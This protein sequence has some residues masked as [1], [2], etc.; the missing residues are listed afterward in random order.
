MGKGKKAKPPPGGGTTAG[1]PLRAAQR[2]FLASLPPR[3]RDRFFSP[4]DVSPGQRADIWERQ[5]DLGEDLVDR[6]AWATPDVRSLGVFRHFGPIC[7]V[8]CGANAYWSR[9]M[10]EQGGVD[11]VALDA[12]LDSGGKIG[13]EKSKKQKKRDRGKIGK[14]S[15]G[16]V[17]R[18]GGPEALM[19]DTELRDSGRTLFL[20][21]PDEEYN[22]P[23]GDDGEAPTSLGEACLQYFTGSTIIHVGELF[24]DT[25]SM[26]QAPFGRSSSGD[27]QARLAAEYHCI[28]KMKL[29]SNWLHVRDTLSVWKRSETSEMVFADGSDDEDA[30]EATYKYVPPE[31]VLPVDVAAPCVAHLLEN[32]NESMHKV[33]VVAS[34]RP[35]WDGDTNV[36]GK[37][38]RAKKKKRQKNKKPEEVEECNDV[39]AGE[40]W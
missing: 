13:G 10:H 38:S 35:S 5:A 31:E 8:G 26:E 39:V 33:D 24:G 23:D 12:S 20:C 6:Y 21:Y 22:Q 7:E 30:E 3:A 9:W 14:S 29:E 1:N 37:G 25:L 36:G 16:L 2:Q 28:L 19:E 18:Q 11:V 4:A 15:G 27:F 40:A 32:S 17:I 34:K